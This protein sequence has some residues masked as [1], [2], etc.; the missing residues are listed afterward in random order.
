MRALYSKYDGPLYNVTRSSDGKSQLIG[1]LSAGGF[2]NK[3][4]HD[5]FCSKL[6]CVI[7]NVMDQSGHDNNLGQR[8]KLINASSHPITST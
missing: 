5:T 4:A 8:H 7:S 1:V 2:A 3:A 6:D